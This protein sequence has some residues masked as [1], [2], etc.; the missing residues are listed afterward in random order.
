MEIGLKKRVLATLQ[1]EKKALNDLN[2]SLDVS[3]WKAVTILSK[4]KGRIIVTGIGKSSFVGMKLVSTLVSLGHSASFL[5]P[6]EALH[7]DT[8]IVNDGDIII[9]FS[10]SGESKE[11]VG[12]IRHIKKQFS[13]KIV[14][15]TGQ[16]NSALAKISDSAIV[17]QITKEGSPQNLAPMAS[18]TASLVLADLLVSAITPH[19][20]FYPEQFAKRH[21][22]GSLSRK[23]RL[24]SEVMVSGKK[25]PLAKSSASFTQVLR[26]MNAKKL[27]II[28]IVNKR[29]KLIGVV[30]D[31]DIRRFLVRGGEARKATVTEVMG[32]SPKV[33]PLMATLAEALHSMELYKIT[34]VF[35]I[36]KKGEPIGLVHIHDIL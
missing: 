20:L 15:I 32:K 5:H 7:G 14:S 13:V 10:F 8:G 31:G 3:F 28:G 1:S 9:S 27:G 24:V 2:K 4:R 29:K 33:I 12:I 26:E 17:F 11:V 22:G 25:L 6:G 19:E 21:P 23:V 35:V 16:K 30:T 34:N 18:T 36:N